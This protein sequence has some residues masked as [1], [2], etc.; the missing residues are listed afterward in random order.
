VI[1]VEKNIIR[2]LENAL[3]RTIWTASVDARLT[4][5][6]YAEGKGETMVAAREIAT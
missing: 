4:M 1:K 3:Q 2:K 5:A 6:E